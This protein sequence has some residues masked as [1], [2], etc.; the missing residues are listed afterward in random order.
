MCSKSQLQSKS[1]KWMKDVRLPRKILYPLLFNFSLFVCTFSCGWSLE[2]IVFTITFSIFPSKDSWKFLWLLA[3]TSHTVFI[4]SPFVPSFEILLPFSR[5]QTPSPSKPSPLMF[6]HLSNWQNEPSGLTPMGLSL[7]LPCGLSTWA[8]RGDQVRFLH[9][10]HLCT[11]DSLKE[12]EGNC[13][14]TA[15]TVLTLTEIYK[16]YVKKRFAFYFSPRVWEIIMHVLC[17]TSKPLWVLR[18]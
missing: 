12:V 7:A 14:E 10:A 9:A 5:L 17:L 11:A 3:G 15:A 4:V 13:S 1:G 2:M 8:L 18:L 6:V 16:P